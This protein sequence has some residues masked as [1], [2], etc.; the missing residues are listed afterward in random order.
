MSEK[1]EILIYQTPQG[2]TKIDV[3]MQDESVWLSQVQMADLFQTTKQN[4]SLH[5]KNIYDE[6][7]LDIESTWREFRQVQ[8]EGKRKVE[9]KIAVYNLDLIISVGYRVKS[10]VGIEFRKWA[11]NKLKEYLVKGYSINT[12]LLK[13]QNQRLV[14]LQDHVNLLQEKVSLLKL[15]IDKSSLSYLLSNSNDFE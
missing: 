3:L 11:T 1:S 8:T 5:I 15:S 2:D 13:K 10:T 7:E 6:G 14:E 4:I 9:R 12:D